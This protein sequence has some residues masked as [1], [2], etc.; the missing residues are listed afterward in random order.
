[1]RSN[2]RGK[3]REIVDVLKYKNL[4]LSQWG[5]FHFGIQVIGFVIAIYGLAG[6]A[7]TTVNLSIGA[8][9]VL[10]FILPLIMGIG[11][12]LRSQYNKDSTSAHAQAAYETLQYDATEG[13]E[14]IRLPSQS[15]I[16]ASTALNQRLLQGLTLDFSEIEHFEA[17]IIRFWQHEHKNQTEYLLYKAKQPSHLFNERKIAIVNSFSASS[18]SLN[19]GKT[20]YF[21][22]MITNDFSGLQLQ[23][24]AGNRTLTSDK[25]LPIS[26]NTLLELPTSRMSNDIGITLLARAEG[27]AVL[28]IQNSKAMMSRD[29]LVATGSGSLDWDDIKRYENDY[30]NPASN[31]VDIVKYGMARELVEESELKGILSIKEIADS[32]L[33]LGYFRWIERGGRPEFVGICD[34]PCSVAQLTPN[35][36]EVCSTS[37]GSPIQSERIKTSQELAQFCEEYLHNDAKDVS[38]PLEVL[39]SRLQA[40]QAQPDSEEHQILQRFWAL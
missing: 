3:A 24:H 35:P 6:S 13:F 15:L 29:K 9:G 4:R 5:Y 11:R 31:F 8:V 12:G 21:S 2:V 23:C 32:I 10:V 30:G 36:N 26:N 18:Q 17:K 38:L 22:S 27:H 40:I 39:L 1:M 34:L 19:I 14:I 20:S 37:N 33:M 28:W 7:P 16:S 25:L